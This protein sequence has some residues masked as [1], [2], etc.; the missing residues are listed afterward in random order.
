MEAALSS[1]MHWVDN[2]EIVSKTRELA[3]SFAAPYNVMFWGVDEGG[4][5]ASAAENRG[6]LAISSEIGG[7][8][9][10]SVDGVKVAERG[11]DNVLKWMGMIEG[12]PDTTQKDGSRGPRHMEVRDQTAY[13]FAPSD[14]LFEP[15]HLAGDQVRSGE[16]AGYLHFIEEWTRAPM[17]IEYRGD[18][19]IWMAP[20]SGRVRKG[21][22][23]NVVMRPHSG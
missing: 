20:G 13:V 18:G 9:R 4:T 8:G 21:D 17:P 3:E 23:L 6:V 22:V 19:T 10:V 14:G 15:L 1:T 16:L 12:K 5:M 11:L 7:Y 2:P